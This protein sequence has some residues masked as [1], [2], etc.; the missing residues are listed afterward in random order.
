M[1]EVRPQLHLAGYGGLRVEVPSP[2]ATEEEI[3]AQID[4]LR[5]NFAEL[6][7]VGRPARDGDHLTI[8]LK[9]SRSGEDRRRP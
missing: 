4:R 6:T 8:D 5:G 9:G 3:D 7:A 1:V 2:V